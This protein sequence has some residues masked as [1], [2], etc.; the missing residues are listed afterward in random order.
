MT[1]RYDIARGHGLACGEMLPLEQAL[2]L[3]QRSEALKRQM[4]LRVELR[5]SMV[6]TLY[7]QIVSDE[8]QKLQ[9]RYD[10]IT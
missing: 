6:G 2:Q 9:K 3:P 8:I 1:S 7:P 5:D 4:V 10:E